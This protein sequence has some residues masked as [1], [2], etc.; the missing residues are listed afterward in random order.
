MQ[1][2][3]HTNGSQARIEPHKVLSVVSSDVDVLAVHGDE[4]SHEEISEGISTVPGR[5]RAGGLQETSA[6]PLK[7]DHDRLE[8]RKESVGCLETMPKQES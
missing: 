6:D 7:C 8:K 2:I 1:G 5:N 4:R 3:R